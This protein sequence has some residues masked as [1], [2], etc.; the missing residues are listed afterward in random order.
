[1]SLPNALV[2]RQRKIEIE[3]AQSNTMVCKQSMNFRLGVEKLARS[4]FEPSRR[5]KRGWGHE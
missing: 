5:K 1:M 4:G 2:L 3:N